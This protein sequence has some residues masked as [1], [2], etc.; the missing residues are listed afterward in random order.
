MVVPVVV[1]ERKGPFG[2]LKGSTEL[3][4]QTWGEQLVGNFSFG[5]MFGLLSLPAF[6]LIIVAMVLGSAC[7]DCAVHSIHGD[8]PDGL[9]VNPIGVAEHFPG[10]SLS[11]RAQQSDGAGRV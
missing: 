10:G 6:G 2:A 7:V 9:V 5:M 1:A 8:L 3:L 11:L 4:R